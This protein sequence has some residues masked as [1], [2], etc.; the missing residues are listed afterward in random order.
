MFGYFRFN[1]HTATYKMK[2]YYKNYYCGT[3]FALEQNYGQLSRML[4]SYDVTLLAILALAYDDADKSKPPCCMCGKKKR[5][6]KEDRW[7]K[8]AAVNILLFSSKLDDDI[9]DEGSL[10]ARLG[11][12]LFGRV[13]KKAKQDYPQLADII[14]QGYLSLA[15]KESKGCEV[16]VMCREFA[17]MMTKVTEH[18]FNL[19]A[20]DRE[21][22]RAIAGWLYFIDQLDDYD[23]D[24]S[25][26]KYNALAVSGI[27]KREY[28]N[29]HI[30]DIVR[31][32]QELMASF[33]EVKSNT[34]ISVTEHRIL[35]SI[36]SET[37][38]SV[39]WRVLSDID[40][41]K[42]LHRKRNVE[43]SDP[44]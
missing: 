41:P 21:Y 7:K 43:W 8:V 39:T 3:C 28:V 16:T 32:L 31:Y 30:S 34:D 5:Q 22:I 15:D 29:T 13:I 4:L 38:P 44:L 10:K 19:P 35:Y 18:C 27:S 20:N 11:K 25:R 17:D 23:K 42:L 33:D 26:G 1:G 40:L 6:F 12:L 36:I 37:I 24:M 9:N 14:D 2:H